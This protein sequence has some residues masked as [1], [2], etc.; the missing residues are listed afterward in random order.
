MPRMADQ[1]SPRRCFQFRLRT[2]FVIV[3]VVA[4]Q[5]A[6]CLPMLREWIDAHDQGPPDYASFVSVEDLSFSLDPP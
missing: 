5:C 4:A 2:L 6:I 3:T 1:P